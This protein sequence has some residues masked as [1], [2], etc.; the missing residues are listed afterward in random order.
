[1]VFHD[2]CLSSLCLLCSLLLTR[3]LLIE[4]VFLCPLHCYVPDLICSTTII[5]RTYVV[6]YFPV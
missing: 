3:V 1:M 4:Y 5:S 6:K 2:S